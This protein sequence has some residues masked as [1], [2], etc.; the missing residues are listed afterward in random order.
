[1]WHSSFGSAHVLVRSGRF[2]TARKTSIACVLRCAP[3]AVVIGRTL[4]IATAMLVGCAAARAD[5]S[6][7]P[8]SVPELERSRQLVLVSAADWGAVSAE[9]RCFERQDARSRWTEVLA[10]KAAL[11]RNG[12][13][14]GSGLHGAPIGSGPVKREGDGKAPAGAFRLIEAFGFASAEDAKLT[15]FPY[16]TLTDDIEGIDDPTS[17]HYNRLVDARSVGTKEWKS[18]E[19][20]RRAGP[21]YRWGVVVG[22]NWNQVPG[23][24]SCIFLHVWEGAGVGT[25]GCTA[26]PEEQ[27]L[28]VIRWL[29]RQKNPILV[30]LP[31]AEYQRLRNPWKLP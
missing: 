29:D 17:R 28:Q 16:R 4:Q 12:L 18:S 6:K 11:G 21:V 30:Q 19:R 23:A 3:A 22:H 26:M 13:G 25:S 31:Q 27:M 9:L 24:G 20:M 8:P 1:M 14:W 5:N 10:T 7:L 2:G 15:R